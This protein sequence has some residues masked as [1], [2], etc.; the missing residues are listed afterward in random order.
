MIRVTNLQCMMNMEWWWWGSHT[1]GGS[2]G[3]MT[4]PIRNHTGWWH[5]MRNY[6]IGSNTLAW[7]VHRTSAKTGASTDF[8]RWIGHIFET[9]RA[10]ADEHLGCLKMTLPD[11]GDKKWKSQK[12]HSNR[13]CLFLLINMMVHS[14]FWNLF[15]LGQICSCPIHA[16]RR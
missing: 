13:T 10:W 2:K 1:N 4:P 8:W 16:T 7:R 12:C 6:E 9:L 15:A 5:R 14:E 11:G 3:I